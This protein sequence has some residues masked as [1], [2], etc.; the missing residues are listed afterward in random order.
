M[1]TRNICKVKGT[2]FMSSLR[3]TV[4]PASETLMR[5]N[6]RSRAPP[7]LCFLSA[8]P[9]LAGNSE[10]ITQGGT[11]GHTFPG[12][13]DGVE[14]T[15]LLPEYPAQCRACPLPHGAWAAH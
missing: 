5:L 15:G 2:R 12:Q 11:L 4:H 1:R 7:A 14:L 3:P 10:W 8:H 13:G 9:T 6:P